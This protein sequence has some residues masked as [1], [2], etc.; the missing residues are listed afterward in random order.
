MNVLVLLVV[1]W[2]N[3]FFMVMGQNVGRYFSQ[4]EKFTIYNLADGRREEKKGTTKLISQNNLRTCFEGILHSS[5][6]AKFLI[7]LAKGREK[8]REE[9]EDVT[10]WH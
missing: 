3:I 9:E 6:S 10:S 2:I 4:L 8:G 1:H 7:N 5:Y